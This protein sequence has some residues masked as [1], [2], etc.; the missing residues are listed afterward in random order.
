MIALS[1]AEAE[2]YATN[3]GTASGLQVCFFLT[4]AGYAV[5]PRVWSDS[6]A[7]RG[8]VRRQG[9]GRM[10][11]LDI[12]HM[13]TQERL[14]KGEFLLKAVGTDKNV[15]D[16]MTKHLAATRMEE[17]LRRLGVLRCARGLV[18]ASLIAGAEAES[19]E[20][21]EDRELSNAMRRAVVYLTLIFAA[22][23]LV[24]VIRYS[25]G[26]WCC[27]DTAGHECEDGEEENAASHTATERVEK[28]VQTEPL[29][30]PAG[31]GLQ[32][33]GGCS[34]RRCGT[35]FA[36]RCGRGGCLRAG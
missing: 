25:R 16:L 36:W 1:S 8:I 28:A 29:G 30:T 5:I 18:V 10:R 34:R 12:R 27:H 17:L 13:W 31:R 24:G 21:F 9:S 32:P 6:S 2:F 4:E 33:G 22:L 35:S 3:R 7:C 20:E 14:Q 23:I 15:G 26:R 11:H 19:L